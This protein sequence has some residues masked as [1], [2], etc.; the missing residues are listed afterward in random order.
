MNEVISIHK[1]PTR[2]GYTFTY[3]KG[4]SYQPDDKYT[5]KGSHTFTAQWEKNSKPSPKPKPTPVHKAKKKVLPKTS[6]EA[7]ILP[8]TTASLISLFVALFA[9]RRVFR[10]EQGGAHRR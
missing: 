6:D 7:P 8:P 3:W 2:E 10:A 5:V 9:C 1:A 4:S